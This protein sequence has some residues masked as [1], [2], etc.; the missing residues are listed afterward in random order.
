MEYLYVYCVSGSSRELRL[1]GTGFEGS[2]LYTISYRDICAVVSCISVKSLEVSGANALIHEAVIESVMIKQGVLPMRF[3]TVLTGEEKVREFLA[4]RYREFRQNIDYLCDKCE[5][6]IRMIWDLEK[7]LDEIRS[8]P[9]FGELTR[10]FCSLK[11]TSSMEYMKR[12]MERH[13]TEQ[14]LEKRARLLVGEIEKRLTRVSL[15]TSIVRL[16]TPKMVCSGSYLVPMEKMSL[17]KGVEEEIK[18]CYP[19]YD[20]LFSG[21]WPP[22]NF[23]TMEGYRDER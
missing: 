5:F 22:Y 21:P 13:Y 11:E 12:A 20:F 8:Q 16:P 6:G 15:K 14:E 19:R 17:V 3:N 2:T 18:T 10:R 1:D 7:I 9:E 4:A 23:V